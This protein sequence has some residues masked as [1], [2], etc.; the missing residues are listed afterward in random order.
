[1]F[2]RVV[3]NLLVFCLLSAAAAASADDLST[4]IE[5]GSATARSA[6]RS[7]EKIAR[8]DDETSKLLSEFRKAQRESEALQTYNQQ[9]SELNAS[10]AKEIEELEAS[11]NNISEL[12]QNLMPMMQRMIDALEKFVSLDLPFL[13]RERLERIAK[14]R[15]LMRSSKIGVGERLRKILEAYAVER[16]YGRSVEAYRDVLK[17]GE[18][19]RDVEFLKVGRIALYYR[20]LDGGSAAIYESKSGAWRKLNSSQSELVQQAIQIAKQRAVPD[21]FKIPAL[22]AGQG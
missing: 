20:S 17:T 13:Q 7:G 15:A 11:L 22:I 5:I 14:L 6:D 19:E 9:L 1:M 4:A 10:Q 16:S 18:A 12:H 21:F 3:K 8:L 2:G